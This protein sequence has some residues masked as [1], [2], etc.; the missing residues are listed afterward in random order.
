MNSD[1]TATDYYKIECVL[2]GTYS[3]EEDMKGK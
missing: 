3:I 1:L 2:K